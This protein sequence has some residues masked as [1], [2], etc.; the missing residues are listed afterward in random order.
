MPEPAISAQDV[1]G[2]YYAGVGV[3]AA[4]GRLIGPGDDEASAAPVAVMSHRYWQRRFDGRAD[5]IGRTILINKVPATIVGVSAAGF[6]GTEQVG[7]T[8]DVSV[9]LAHFL[10]FQPD[11]PGRA[12]PGYWWL[13][14]MARLAPGATA[15]QAA[16]GARARVP[17]GCA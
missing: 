6:D 17:G 9:P 16:G 3:A 1:S 7:E 14:V 15:E 13:S 11:R 4:V 8:V 5:A 10:L 2:D 12:K